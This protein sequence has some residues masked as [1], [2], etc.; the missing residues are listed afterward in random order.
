MS[1]AIDQPPVNQ[2][3]GAAMAVKHFHHGAT[4]K[5]DLSQIN[6]FYESPPTTLWITFFN[7]RLYWCFAEAEADQ[8][9]IR[10][11]SGFVRV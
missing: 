9:R 6:T 8:T 5:D 10:R 2:A 11:A 7:R 3:A 4:A 1:G